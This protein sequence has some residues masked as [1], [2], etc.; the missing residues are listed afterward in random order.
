MIYPRELYLKR[1]RGFYDHP[2]LIKVITGIRRCGKSSL[3]ESIKDEL[4]ARGVAE[5]QIIHFNLD[6]RPYKAV[7]APSQLEALIEEKRAQA[8]D[9]LV[10]LCIDEIQNVKG[11]EPLIESYRLEGNVSLFIT[12]SNSYLLSGELVTKL[13]GRYVEFEMLP[14]CFEEYLG[15]KRF[16]HKEVDAER[17]KEF[18][19]YLAEGGFPGALLFD[20]NEDKRNYVSAL[21]KEIIEKDVRKRLKIRDKDL[22]DAL[23]DFMVGNYG[24]TMDRISLH[25]AF[26]AHY[27]KPVRSQTID[28]YLQGLLDAKILYECKRFDTKSKTALRGEKKYYLAD[29][30]LRSQGLIDYGP[31]LE[32]VLFQFHKGKGDAVSI[33][34]VGKLECDFILR[35]G[36]DYS[37][38]QVAMTLHENAPRVLGSQKK[39]LLDREYEPL[40]RINDNYPK[41][42]LTLDRFL[43]NRSGITHQNLLD[44]FAENMPKI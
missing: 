16:F 43:V 27:G 41:Y 44:Y 7:K 24:A 11:F 5:T 2:E 22:F 40:E 36:A 20:E 3:L 31:A 26:S 1:I 29:L 21:V 33:G 30:S 15:M 9:S 13:T 17:E 37:Y 32:N 10:Y 35:R 19:S 34:K 18:A 23:L 38:L 12:G 25:K 8:S 6:K 42:V 28:R 14:L 4:R 39:T